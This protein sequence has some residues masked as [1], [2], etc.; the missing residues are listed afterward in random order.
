[1][2]SGWGAKVSG[3]AWL[4][5]SG[6]VGAFCSRSC[7]GLSPSARRR[8]CPVPSRPHVLL[9]CAQGLTLCVVA[10][11]DLFTSNCMYATFAVSEGGLS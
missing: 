3:R 8:P 9:I 2:V 1:M 6:A 11:A 10:G 7:A 4:S 5:P